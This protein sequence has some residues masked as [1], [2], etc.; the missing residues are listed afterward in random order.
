MIAQLDG[1]KAGKN[2]SGE[3][4]DEDEEPDF[5]AAAMDCPVA[6]GVSAPLHRCQGYVL[7][8]QFLAKY[9]RAILLET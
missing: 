6:P 7:F 8:C 4:D 5:Y 3:K 1:A 2:L 9:Y